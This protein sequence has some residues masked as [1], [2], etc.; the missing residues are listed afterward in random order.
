MRERERQ[1]RLLIA[2]FLLS[3]TAHRI[4]TH[5]HTHGAIDDVR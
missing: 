4:N 3:A 5:T 1:I 2:G